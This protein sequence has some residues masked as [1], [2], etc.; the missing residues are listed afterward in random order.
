MSFAEMEGEL[1][2][3]ARSFFKS[4]IV[5]HGNIRTLCSVQAFLTVTNCSLLRTFG[6]SARN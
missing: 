5:V 2:L 4:N 1:K 3:S 6:F